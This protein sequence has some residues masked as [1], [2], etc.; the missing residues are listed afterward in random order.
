MKRPSPHSN[1]LTMPRPTT[2]RQERSWDYESV[3]LDPY[4]GRVK[5]RLRLMF[6]P[7]RGVNLTAIAHVRTLII[8]I[9][10]ALSA[11]ALSGMRPTS[12]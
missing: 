3:S 7:K 2:S 11:P 4:S 8:G 9:S 6:V 10:L 1:V 5:P 12:S